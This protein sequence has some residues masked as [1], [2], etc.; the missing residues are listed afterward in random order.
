MVNVS[1]RVVLVVQAYAFTKYLGHLS[2]IFDE[3]GEI[4]SWDGEPIL[5]NETFDKHL[6]VV[7]ELKP[8]RERIDNFITIATFVL[9]AGICLTGMGCIF[10]LLQCKKKRRERKSE[11][12]RAMGVHGVQPD[13]KTK[14]IMNKNWYDGIDHELNAMSK[15]SH[16]K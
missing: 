11:N 13:N 14:R 10:V 7:K 6:H 5:L 9:L 1:D 8:L 2:V 4:V 3:E 12:K 16:N 15:W